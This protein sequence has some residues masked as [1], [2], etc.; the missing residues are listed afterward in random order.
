IDIVD[1]I[2]TVDQ[3]TGKTI[4]GRN[5]FI[6]LNFNEPQA[7]ACPVA[8]VAKH[9][10]KDADDPH[11]MSRNLNIDLR[12]HL[13]A[14]ANSDMMPHQLAYF[15][16]RFAP[17]WSAINNE[18]IKSDIDCK[19]IE[20]NDETLQSLRAQGIDRSDPRYVSA[21]Q[22]AVAS[23]AHKKLKTPI[24]IVNVLLCSNG[25]RYDDNGEL[26]MPF[27][28]PMIYDFSKGT[29]AMTEAERDFYSYG[30]YRDRLILR[31]SDKVMDRE[32]GNDGVGKDKFVGPSF[33]LGFA[34]YN[35]TDPRFRYTWFLL[36]ELQEKDSFEKFRSEATKALSEQETGGKNAEEYFKYQAFFDAYDKT[37]EKL[38]HGKRV[39]LAIEEL[40]FEMGKTMTRVANAATREELKTARV[41]H[42]KARR[43]FAALFEDHHGKKILD[44]SRGEHATYFNFSDLFNHSVDFDGTEYY[45][46]DRTAF[47]CESDLMV[48]DKSGKKRMVLGG[49]KM[50]I[51]R[52]PSGNGFRWLQFLRASVP[53]S[54]RVIKNKFGEEM[55]VPG[56][57]AVITIPADG[58]KLQGTD[59]DGDKAAVATY[60]DTK[61]PTFTMYGNLGGLKVKTPGENGRDVYPSDYWKLLKGDEVDKRDLGYAMDNVLHQVGLTEDGR[62]VPVNAKNAVRK[63]I[64]LRSDITRMSQNFMLDLFN[65]SDM[66]KPCLDSEGKPFFSEAAGKR[67]RLTE[68]LFGTPLGSSIIVKENKKDKTGKEEDD[69][70]SGIEEKKIE[71]LLSPNPFDKPGVSPGNPE[72]GTKVSVSSGD[73]N[74]ARGIVVAQVGQ[75]NMSYATGVFGGAGRGLSDWWDVDKY[76]RPFF[77]N[78]D[79]VGYN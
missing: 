7:V 62:E 11:I 16:S 29:V 50:F 47:R 56:I 75:L 54:E 76:G 20:E 72:T 41:K 25:S 42:L 9:A 64:R 79:F 31:D 34:Q 36:S 69:D 66:S 22:T 53:V 70:N 58:L 12:L 68:T 71:D 26:Y 73:S 57:D 6:S 21:L 59:N 40:A 3:T 61:T 18:I 4:E 55:V 77:E 44:R 43:D 51:P 39:S 63:T 5:T 37:D 23:K 52:T 24:S 67:R 17:E 2:P 8:N 45:T 27:A 46:F 19:T 28:S 78:V 49:E 65:Y 10:E 32:H 14:G 1:T 30:A 13:Y 48:R 60:V 38:D 74:V 35:S 15:E 33:H